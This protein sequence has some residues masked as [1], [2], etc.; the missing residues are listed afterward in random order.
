MLRDAENR[1]ARLMARGIRVHEP[2]CV[3]VGVWRSFFEIDP[4]RAARQDFI[5]MANWKLE[6]EVFIVWAYRA[7]VTGFFRTKDGRMYVKYSPSSPL[8]ELYLLENANNG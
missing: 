1:K 6:I 3:S 5:G 4:A 8:S 7:Q 2:E